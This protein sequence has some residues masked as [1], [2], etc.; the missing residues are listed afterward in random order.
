MSPF[1]KLGSYAKT[2]TVVAGAIGVIT[3]AYAAVGLPIPA[4]RFYVDEKMAP[5]SD[6]V[7]SIKVIVLNSS[8]D[9]INAS[10]GLLRNEKLAIETSMPTLA[11]IDKVTMTSRLGRIEDEMTELDRRDDKLRQQLQETTSKGW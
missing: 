9:Q 8:R 4:S 7:K 5:I 1:A 3:T 2:L 11:P 10:K 6:A